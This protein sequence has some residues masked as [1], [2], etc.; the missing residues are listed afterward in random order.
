MLEFNPPFHVQIDRTTYELLPGGGERSEQ[1]DTVRF[2][3][4]DMTTNGCIW[5]TFD[6]ETNARV[7][8]SDPWE[9]ELFMQASK[10]C[11]VKLLPLEAM[12]LSCWL[13]TDSG[14]R[15]RYVVGRL[16]TGD[17]FVESYNPEGS[18]D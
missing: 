4:R 16:D 17:V 7:G 15:K 5:F 14:G 2:Q 12:T 18:T 3:Y 9:I 11:M 8:V 1:P 10:R 13:A 6:T